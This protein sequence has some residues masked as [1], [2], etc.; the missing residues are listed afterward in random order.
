MDARSIA[1]RNALFMVLE[2]ALFY[3][4]LSFIPNETVVARFIDYT[5][6]SLAL[7]GFAA[8]MSAFSFYLGE[9]I[10]GLFVHKIKKQLPFM[11]KSAFLSRSLLMAFAL[12]LVAGVKS[13]AAAYAFV[14][15]YAVIFIIDGF[16]G[17]CWFQ[18][19]ARTMP[20]KKRGEVL[21]LQQ[22]LCGAIGVLSGFA[23]QRILDSS[24]PEMRKYTLIFMIAGAIF[25]LSAATIALFKD[26]PH[27]SSPTE[28]VKNPINYIK[29]LLPLLKQSRATR[30]VIIGRM[31]FL[32]AMISSPI[33]YK[34][35]ELY[36]LSATQLSYLVY[37]P[38]IGQILAGV[39]WSQIS[40]RT[41]YPIMM[42]LAQ[43]C[44]VLCALANITALIAGEAGLGVMLPLS[45]AMA[46][47]RFTNVANNAFTQHVIAIVGERD[48][49]NYIVLVS[50]VTA[51][52]TFGTALAGA[53]ADWA[54]WPVYAIMLTCALAG[55]AQTWRFFI[56]KSSPLNE[57]ERV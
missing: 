10:C 37:M 6:G 16:V 33:N 36:G 40:R 26:V 53:I 29:E 51:P 56:S 20:V 42:M 4:G 24:Q 32:M 13:A 55:C 19:Q 44:G 30:Q 27:P 17:L 14:A 46:L 28:P 12:L 1:R 23:L 25:V 54:F 39:F 7:A 34:F 38:F 41:N 52:A 35:G 47:L 9:F 5:S 11:I 45:V 50:L 15:I 31:L 21:S 8:S 48:R 18:V 57:S 43:I 2:G 3:A 22:T 49:A